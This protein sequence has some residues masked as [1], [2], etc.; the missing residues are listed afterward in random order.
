MQQETELCGLAVYWLPAAGIIPVLLL[1][2]VIN[3]NSQTRTH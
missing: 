2:F 3:F 1:L